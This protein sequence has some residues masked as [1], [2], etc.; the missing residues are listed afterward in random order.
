MDD[1]LRNTLNLI[2]KL[3]A[4]N[5]DF[6]AELQKLY[7]GTSSAKSIYNSDIL[8]NPIAT[9]NGKI[10]SIYELC[11]EKVLQKQAIQFYEDFPIENLLFRS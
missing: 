4:T 9:G 10:D 2:Q 6:K 7:G 11:V 3:A 5:K 8:E 1:K